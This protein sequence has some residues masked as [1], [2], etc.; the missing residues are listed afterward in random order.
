MRWEGISLCLILCLTS[1]ISLPIS[2]VGLKDMNLTIDHNSSYSLKENNFEW[3]NQPKLR[4]FNVVAD[5]D[6][7]QVEEF[8]TPN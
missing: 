1:V 5:V 4:D 8:T 6:F 3:I 2:T 7:Q